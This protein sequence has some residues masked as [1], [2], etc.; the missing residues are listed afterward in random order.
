MLASIVHYPLRGNEDVSESTSP[1]R[2]RGRFRFPSK[3]GCASAKK[4]P[5]NIPAHI[6]RPL[7]IAVTL[8]S[9]L[10]QKDIMADLGVYMKRPL[11]IPVE[12]LMRKLAF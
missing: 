6:K 9:E 11:V 2:K 7:H 4:V 3:R 5:Y 10:V 8:A 12:E 1:P